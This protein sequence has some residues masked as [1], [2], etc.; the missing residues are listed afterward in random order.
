ME[1]KNLANI[2]MKKY[3]G[4]HKEF[5][6]PLNDIL[7]RLAEVKCRKCGNQYATYLSYLHHKELLFYTTY[8]Y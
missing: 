3:V 6:L 2:E 5:P 1:D 4:P 8:I 7:A